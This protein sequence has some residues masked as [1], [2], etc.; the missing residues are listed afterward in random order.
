[1]EFIAPTAAVAAMVS[2]QLGAA[3]STQLFAALS[4]AGTAWLRL[5][6]AGVVLLA[7]TRPRITRI[8]PAVLLSTLALGAVTGLMMVSFIE[9]VARL[10]LGMVVAIEFLGP[11]SVAALRAHRRSALVWPALAL[12]GV[13]TL[14]QPWVGR[15]DPAGIGFAVGAA[16]GWAGYILLTHRIGSQLD[17]MGGL[18]LS[19]ATAAVVIAPIGAWGAVLGLTVPTAAAGLGVAVLVPLLP[20]ILELWALRR[21][22]LTAFGTLMAVEPAVAIVL[23]WA[24]LHQSVTLVQLGG[25]TLVVIAGICAQ[26]VPDRRETLVEAV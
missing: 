18:A 8:P 23:G 21:M 11:L 22:P 19:L 2:V 1:M 3:L 5:L 4:P 9:A 13:I 20:Y 12:V 15:L 26:R 16:L 14:T 25:V 24:I 7:F 6:V 10:P 17:G